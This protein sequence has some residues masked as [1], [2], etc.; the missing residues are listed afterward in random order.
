M[1]SKDEMNVCC[2]YCGDHYVHHQNVEVFE[3]IGG[4]DGH[5]YSMK[6]GSED[7]L[8]TN[9]NPSKRRN[10]IRIEFLGECNHRFFMDVVQHKGVTYIEYRDGS[11]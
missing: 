11:F 5:S 1:I 7:K 6:P 2:P 3:R 4:E 9:G 10:A 8:L